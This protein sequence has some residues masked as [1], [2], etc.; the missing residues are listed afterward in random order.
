MRA[1]YLLNDR[2][3]I[4]QPLGEGGMSNVYLARDLYLQRDVAVKVLRL[5]LRDD[6][7][8]IRRFQREAYSL[9]DLN[10]PHIVSIYDVDEADG[11]HYLVMEYVKGTNLKNYLAEHYPLTCEQ[12]VDLMSQILDGVIAAH[13]NGVIH[14]DLKPQNI[15][16]D[17]NNQVKITD[18]GIAVAMA[19]TMTKTHTL[20]GSVYY[21][22]PEQI[23][24]EL[25]SE[26]SDIYSLGII[27]FELLAGKVPFTGD[28]PLA[29]AMKHCNQQ[30]SLQPVI[31]KAP[32]AM[33]NII[34]RATSKDPSER[35]LKALEMQHDLLS[36]LNI[37]RANEPRWR[38]LVNEVV[39]NDH[40]RII[41]RLQDDQEYADVTQTIEMK[42]T[43]P[44][45]KRKPPAS[46]E[47][48]SKKQQESLPESDPVEVEAPEDEPEEHHISS[49]AILFV[50]ALIILILLYLSYGNGLTWHNLI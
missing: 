48:H 10:N 31:D 44:K 4:V 49:F 15:L 7:T 40:T 19:S 37:A 5:D 2:Y 30:V 18:F 12:V 16:I 47:K 8:A 24:G 38:P 26:Q 20:V 17:E 23:N 34:A 39:D 42:F 1:G 45:T 25:A 36:C 13:Q 6:P 32:I 22:S 29:I 33:Q 35:Y 14:R 27:L 50:M 46:L 28:N 11:L 21:I 3:Q 9:V 41:P 43:R